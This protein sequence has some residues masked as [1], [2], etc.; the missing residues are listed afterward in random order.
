MT[1]TQLKLKIFMISLEEA[2]LLARTG[3]IATMMYMFVRHSY[4]HFDK[5]DQKCISLH[6]LL[7]FSN[8]EDLEEIN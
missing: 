1:D 4:E 6:F 8:L 7:V 5:T 3:V 2:N